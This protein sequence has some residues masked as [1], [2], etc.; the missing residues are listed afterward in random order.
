MLNSANIQSYICSPTIQSYPPSNHAM[1]Q[2]L[3]S[4]FSG[5]DFHWDEKLLLLCKIKEEYVIKETWGKSIYTIDARK[6]EERVYIR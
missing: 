2:V 5:S 3:E 1:Y 6:H 4:D